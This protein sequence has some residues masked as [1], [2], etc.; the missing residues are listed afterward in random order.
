MV[1]EE[2]EEG[3]RRRRGEPCA[4]LTEEAS[5]SDCNVPVLRRRLPTPATTRSESSICTTPRSNVVYRILIDPIFSSLPFQSI[6]TRLP[7]RAAPPS[8]TT[9]AASETKSPCNAPSH[10][11]PR[12]AAQLG[13]HFTPDALWRDS[14]ALHVAF[15]SLPPL[16]YSFNFLKPSFCTTLGGKYAL[17]VKEW[18]EVDVSTRV[19]P[20]SRRTVRTGAG[21]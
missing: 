9:L 11:P 19:A 13:A 20:Q 4:C 2:K 6:P 1:A 3:E 7:A 21:V 16:F 18:P 12:G 14:R 8:C 5:G 10:T 17:L 15:G